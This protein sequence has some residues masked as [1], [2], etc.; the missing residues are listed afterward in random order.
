[1]HPF[2]F[3]SPYLSS[4]PLAEHGLEWRWTEV[5]LS[6][7]LDDGTAGVLRRSLDETVAG[8][9]ADG[10]AWRRSF[11]GFSEHFSA[12]AED[13]FGPILHVPS[14]PVI[15]GK[16]GLRAMLPAT[17]FASRFSTDR[18]RAMFASVAVHS[19]TPLSFP[20]TAGVG[21]L[22]IAAA[23]SGGW[24]IAAGGSQSIA[25]AMTGLLTSLGGRIETGA[26]VAS[27]A[28]LPPSRVRLF[29]TSAR[30]LASIAGDALPARTRRAYDRFRYGPAAFKVDLAVEGG[31]PWRDEA[32]PRAGTVHLGGTLEEIVATEAAVYAGTMPERPF[33]LLAQ[34]YLADPSRS[35]GNVHPIWAYAHVPNG[36]PHDATDAVIDQIE[37]FAPG[38]RDRIV[39]RHVMGPS[40][41]ES[42]N[43]NYVGG[44]IAGGA[45][46]LRQLLFRP[47][48]A[49]NP[50]ATGIPGTY[51]CSAATPPGGGVHGMCGHH[52]AR[53]AVR[54]LERS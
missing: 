53:H 20:S 33:V 19:Y 15:T 49:L 51:L 30:A 31:I 6:H 50:Y 32:S 46:D 9:G 23:H 54:Y 3:G 5:D 8:L 48:V 34:Q 40:A 13:F 39:G 7:P 43:A 4:L 42:M 44:D 12:I 14:H 24:P 16:F 11:G 29:D 47:R 10:E 36:Y 26:N 25:A 2:G 41:L 1:V 28:D 21:A 35:A 18:A 27:L 22:F 38:T 17:R 52:A 37:R 45:N